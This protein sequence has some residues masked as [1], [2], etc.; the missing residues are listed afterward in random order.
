[1]FSQSDCS[2]LECRNAFDSTIFSA[3]EEDG[4][5]SRA[6]VRDILRRF[7]LERTSYEL[8]I[9][10][11]LAETICTRAARLYAC[12]IAAI[13]RRKRIELCHF[14]VDGFMFSNYPKFRKR[15]ATAL[16]EFLDGPED[17]EDP[18][19]LYPAEDDSTIGAALIAALSLR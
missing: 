16:R 10:A 5:D 8:N 11:D 1:M 13:C 19:M 14:G 12:G 2:K 17:S 6:A 18:V 3:I 15:A 4:T 7:D 9:C